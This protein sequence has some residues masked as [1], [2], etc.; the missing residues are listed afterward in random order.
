MYFEV[1]RF[2]EKGISSAYITGDQH[3]EDVL[4]GVTNGK[5]KLG[6]LTSYIA[7]DQHNEDVLSGVTNGKFKLVY[8]RCPY[9]SE[10][11]GGAR[12]AS[13][14]FEYLCSPEMVGTYPRTYITKP[15]APPHSIIKKFFLSSCG[16]K[17]HYNTMK[18]GDTNIS[19]LFEVL[20]DWINVLEG[21]VDFTSFFCT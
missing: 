17:L 2:K 5:F 10:G 18:S 15:L 1:A 16:C 11:V 4:S 7:G 20:E 3:N 13:S 14:I 19:C 9:F 12:L 6:V 8:F 21:F